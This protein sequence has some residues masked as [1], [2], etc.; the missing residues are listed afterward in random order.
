MGWK[1]VVIGTECTVSL[2][3][4]R[5]KITIGNE[6]QNIPLCDLDT[7]IFSHDRIT[8]TIPMLSK[9]VENNINVIICDSKNDPIGIFQPFNNHSL[10]FKQLNKQ[11]NWKITRKKKLWK[12]IIEQKIQSE[13]DVLDLIYE[14]CDELETLIGYKNS[15]YNDDQTNREA[16]SAK[17]YFGKMFG[18][19]FYRDD[20]NDVRNFALN[21]GYKILASYISKCIT[22]RG[23]L[24]Q[25]GIHHIGESNAFNLTYDFIE[26]LRVIVD[27]W[28]EENIKG[29]F[30]VAQKQELI[31]LL[32]TKIY[33]DK[34]WMR[35]KDAIE[36][37]IDSYIGFLN[38]KT[39]DILKV[40]F[41]KGILMEGS[42]RFVR[43]V[44]FFDLPQETKTDQRHYRQFV[45]YLKTEGF[46]RIQYSVYAKL[47]INND[48]AKTIQKRLK[49]NVPDNGDIRYLI[50]TERQYQNIVNM[51]SNYTLQENI[52]TTDRTLIIGGLNSENNT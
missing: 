38:E 43:L 52:T 8:M 11:I 44:L 36:D 39:D 7:V 51:N 16:V 28:V 49:N 6:Y 12:F 1:T 9:L 22:A 17:C 26:P 27:A 21:Y 10:V 40:D 31:G 4:N 41:S 25:L 34:K 33:I 50:I 30:S 48:S 37:L 14:D 29:S 35:L 45:K 18:T 5:M 42:S 13:I 2:T 47:C 3:L 32:E 46:I 19:K 15:V 20:K 24:T 23:L